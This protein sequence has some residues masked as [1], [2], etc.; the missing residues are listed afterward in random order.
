MDQYVF[1]HNSSTND[2]IFCIHQILEKK[3]GIQ[4]SCA[5]ALYRLQRTVMIQLGGR[6]F[7]I[8]S[9]NLVSP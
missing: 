8:F 7:I 3:M 4:R 6:S 9:L 1:E 5:S 2:H